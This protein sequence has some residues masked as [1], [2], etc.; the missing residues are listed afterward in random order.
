MVCMAHRLHP[1]HKFPVHA[2]WN[3]QTQ[4]KLTVLSIASFSTWAP[5]PESRFELDHNHMGEVV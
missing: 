1:K 2:T 4:L 5:G 3:V